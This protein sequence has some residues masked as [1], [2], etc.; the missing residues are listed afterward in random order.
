ML[1]SHDP[2]RVFPSLAVAEE[3]FEG[4]ASWLVLY[5]V[6]LNILQTMMCQFP[7]VLRCT[8]P[9]HGMGVNIV[10]TQLQVMFQLIG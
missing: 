1:T 5:T 2:D 9:P 10:D 6:R 3:Y 7:D 8:T 4:G